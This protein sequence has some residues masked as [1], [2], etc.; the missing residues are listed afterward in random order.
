[1]EENVILVCGKFKLLRLHP[2][3]KGEKKKLQIM[4]KQYKQYLI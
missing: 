1:M 3:N 4:S 2:Q